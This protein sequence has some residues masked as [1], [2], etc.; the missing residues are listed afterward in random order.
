MPTL[1]KAHRQ[2]LRQRVLDAYP[3]MEPQVL[4]ILLDVYEKD[5]QWLQDR[6]SAELRKEKS[7]ARLAKLNEQPGD[8]PV[9]TS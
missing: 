6:M 8:S 9:P 3:T 4:D 2:E 5:S 7:A 1:T